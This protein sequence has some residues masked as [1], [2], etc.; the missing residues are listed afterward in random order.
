M[1]MLTFFFPR[2]RAGRRI[3]GNS[4]GGT[5]ISRRRYSPLLMTQIPRMLPKPVVNHRK[6]PA[7]L[8]WCCHY[9]YTLRSARNVE[10]SRYL[11]LAKLYQT[12]HKQIKARIAGMAD[13]QLLG[14]TVRRTSC[15]ENFANN[16]NDEDDEDD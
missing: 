2:G 13:R 14:C 7:N 6:K 5:A 10:V 12:P 3:W 1:T 9:G 11:E 4:T 15:C 16:N 8:N